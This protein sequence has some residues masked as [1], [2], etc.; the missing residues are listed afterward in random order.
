[1]ALLFSTP[2]DRERECAVFQ[3]FHVMGYCGVQRDL[4]GAPAVRQSALDPEMSQLLQ[5]CQ[6]FELARIRE[7]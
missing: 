4:D 3:R 2:A 7:R 5:D 6:G 1:M